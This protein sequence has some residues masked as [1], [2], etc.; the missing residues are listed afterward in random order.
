[1]TDDETKVLWAETNALLRKLVSNTT[2]SAPA[3]VAGVVLAAVGIGGGVTIVDQIIRW[4][5]VLKK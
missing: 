3:K 4:L 2:T 5:E 1:M